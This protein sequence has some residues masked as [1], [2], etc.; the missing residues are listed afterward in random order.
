VIPMAPA[1]TDADRRVLVAAALQTQKESEKRLQQLWPSL[2]WIRQEY[3]MD[4]QKYQIALG[5]WKGV[6]TLWWEN[7]MMLMDLG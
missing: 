6:Q 7:T 5:T 2:T 4:S 3:G 1:E